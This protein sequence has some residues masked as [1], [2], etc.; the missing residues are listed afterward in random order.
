MFSN[1]GEISEVYTKFRRRPLKALRQLLRMRRK[2][3]DLVIDTMEIQFG[4]IL[5]LRFLRPRWLIGNTGYHDY[6]GLRHADLNMYDAL[7]EWR[8]VHTSLRML[9]FLDLIG[10]TD[11]D[12]RMGFPVS[13]ESM[14]FAKAFTAPYRNN[15]LIGFNIDTSDPARS[16]SDADFIDIYH[17]LLE[18]KPDAVVLMFCTPDR[19]AHFRDLANSHRLSNLILEKGS[20]GFFDAAAIVKFV[21]IM[22]TTNTSFIHIAS[23]FDTPTV[24]IYHNDSHHL[25]CWGPRSSLH[26]VI[27]PAEPGDSTRGFSTSAVTDAAFS[28]LEQARSRNGADK[29]GT[30]RSPT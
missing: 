17:Q 14:R 26:A 1:V 10:V 11:Y 22:I 27:T 13:G 20:S 6:R 16:V 23:A 18:R 2:R 12:D 19:Q 9:S 5:A 28:L 15:L 21:D 30:S 4:K 25:R 29:T 8:E 24:G 3:Y 7:S